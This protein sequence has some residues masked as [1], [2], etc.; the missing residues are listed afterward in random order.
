MGKEQGD[1]D[2]ARKACSLEVHCLKC[3]A[4]G[5]V[6]WDKLNRVLRCSNCGAWYRVDHDGRLVACAGP[7]S[8]T[9]Q[10]RAGFSSWEDAKVP[11][12]APEP[13]E[14]A[15]RREP[16]PTL[17]D[18]LFAGRRRYVT[19]AIG[20]VGALL[21]GFTWRSMGSSAEEVAPPSAE[22]PDTLEE[23]AVE[24]TRA[25]LHD[26]M[27]TMLRLTDPTWDRQLRQWAAKTP[28]PAS[29]ASGDERTTTIE[30]VSETKR[31][32]G[33][34]KV[35]VRIAVLQG[36][37]G[38]VERTIESQWKLQRDSWIFCPAVSARR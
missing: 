13:E 14:L 8:V 35:A 16:D 32:N 26:D 37:D 28:V 23:R 6:P 12:R 33:V 5:A 4:G 7:S 38:P 9:V 27:G 21:A 3:G 1:S 36:S 11:L 31:P 24:F 22:L 19:A 18:I 20:L 2:G 30:F 17:R 10:V 15:T 34:S 25:W 29:L